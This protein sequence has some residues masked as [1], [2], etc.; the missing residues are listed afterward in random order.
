MMLPS[1]DRGLP[2]LLHVTSGV[3]TPLT[4]HCM[5]SFVSVSDLT[6]SP[7]LMLTGV[8][9]P[10]GKTLSF[11]GTSMNGLTGSDKITCETVVV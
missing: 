2:S 5:L 7:I 9:S 8:P 10:T 1:S 4:G 6:L 11:S 3:G